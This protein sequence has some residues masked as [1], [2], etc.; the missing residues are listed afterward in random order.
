MQASVVVACRLSCSM[1]CSILGPGPGIKPM[2][3]ALTDSQPLDHQGSPQEERFKCPLANEFSL[4]W[5]K[6]R[7]QNLLQGH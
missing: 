4:P 2:S 3:P 6:G 5:G 7:K 1:A